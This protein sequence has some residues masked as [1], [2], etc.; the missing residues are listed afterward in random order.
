MRDSRPTSSASPPGGSR[1]TRSMSNDLLVFSLGLWNLRDELNAVTGL[2][3]K[4]AMFGNRNCA[5]VAGWG[6]KPTARRARRF[7]ARNGKP[8]IAFEDGFLRSIR[9]GA[10]TRPMSLIMD[11]S[12]IYYDAR[13][14]SD[15]ENM[16]ASAD[17]SGEEIETA[18]AIMAA[19]RRDRLSKYNNAPIPFEI[20]PSGG[21]RKRILIL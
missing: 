15:L 1:S 19:L 5:A 9:P 6:H 20:L 7:A 11:R 4:L 18:E 2:T 13:G 12:G 17:F 21:G 3:P 10:E 14:P 16:L 8:Y